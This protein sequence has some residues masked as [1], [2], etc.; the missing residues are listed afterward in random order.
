MREG[1]FGSSELDQGLAQQDRCGCV[2]WGGASR[3]PGL[4]PDKQRLRLEG[5]GSHSTFWTL[6]SHQ[7]SS[8]KPQLHAFPIV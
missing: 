3:L 6:K 4:S 1:P 5:E 2:C 8:L 7:N